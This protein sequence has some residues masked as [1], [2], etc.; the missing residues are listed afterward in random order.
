MFNKNKRNYGDRIDNT[1]TVKGHSKL[2]QNSTL[3]KATKKD[4]DSKI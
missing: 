4:P 2:P 3:S 1:Y